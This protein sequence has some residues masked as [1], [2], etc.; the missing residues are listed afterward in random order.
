MFEQFWYIYWKWNK[1]KCL[2][3]SIRGVLVHKASVK[4]GSG[5]DQYTQFVFKYLKRL[6]FSKMRINY[7][8]VTSSL[9]PNTYVTKF[10][11]FSVLVLFA[12]M[13]FPMPN[14]C[15]VELTFNVEKT[16][17]YGHLKLCHLLLCALTFPAY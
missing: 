13:Q 3:F 11:E 12:S 6:N 16:G 14:T 10:T 2:N 5:E 9:A 15:M 4:A 1:V 8:L 17:I 7:N